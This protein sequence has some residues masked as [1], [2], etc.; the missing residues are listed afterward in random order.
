MKKRTITTLLALLIFI[1]FIIWGGFPFIFIVFLLATRCLVEL[2]RMFKIS[3]YW[4]PF[5]LAI[6]LLW[7][8]L[9]PTEGIV[10]EAMWFEKSEAII[11]MLLLLL[12]YTVLVKNKF[13][14][15]QAGI[16]FFS[17]IYVGMGFFY[18]IETRMD[19]G[20]LANIIFAFLIIWSTD[21]GAYLAGRLFGKH[22]L[23][24]S[25]SPKKTIEGAIGGV[26]LACILAGVFH[27]IYPFS[28]PTVIVVI[29]TITASIFGQVGDLVESALK[30]HYDVKDSGRILPGHGGIL[31]RFD[32]LLF[33]LPLLHF[34]QFM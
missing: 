1:P 5:S 6:I 10:L 28:H 33:V 14:F 12:S 3:N 13:T 29:V 31:D 23:W 34:I 30:R 8:V 2:L 22:K 24:P 11:I 18:L 32:S 7:L 4:V 9:L 21:T 26:V 19:E 16:I 20:G 17:T 25:I 15:D 27:I